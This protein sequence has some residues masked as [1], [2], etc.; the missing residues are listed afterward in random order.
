MRVDRNASSVI[1]AARLV[2]ADSDPIDS[3]AFN[4]A[5]LTVQFLLPG[6]L[7][8]A[9]LTLVDGVLGS[10]V[11]RSWE[12]YPD[13]PESPQDGTY[14]FC[15]PDN[16][17]VAG[18]ATGVRFKVGANPWQYDAIEAVNNIA[19]ANEQEIADRVLSGISAIRAQLVGVVDNGST[20]DLVLTQRTDWNATDGRAVEFDFEAAGVDFT[21]ATALFGTSQVGG[22]AL[23]A[24]ATVVN[25]AVGSCTVR[26]TFTDEDLNHPS[27]VYQFNVKVVQT[28]GDGDKIPV[29]RGTITLSEDYTEA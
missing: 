6:S 17:I 24:T 1:L 3:L 20:T 21:G 27:G 14:Q 16:W 15:V 5:S 4:D 18:K 2:D 23:S 25:A 10:W 26:L 29:T 28:A 9:T 19:E 22:E 7:A 12:A 11:S 8:W 13:S